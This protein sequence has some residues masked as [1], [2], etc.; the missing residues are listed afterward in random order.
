MRSKD[1]C[2]EFKDR[3]ADSDK[4]KQGEKGMI[5]GAYWLDKGLIKDSILLRLKFSG[6]ANYPESENNIYN[7]H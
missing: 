2:V 1:C 3:I 5:D 7:N 4:K 6:S